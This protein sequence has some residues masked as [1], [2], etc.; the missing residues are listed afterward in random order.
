VILSNGNGY[1]AGQVTDEGPN[2]GLWYMASATATM[3][4]RTQ[5]RRE[6]RADGVP[7]SMVG[8]SAIVNACFGVF[9]NSN[10]RTTVE[11][12]TQCQSVPAFG[13][14][15]AFAWNHEAAHMSA[16]LS[17]AQGSQGNVYLLWE[18]RMAGSASEL[19]VLADKDYFDAHSAIS[20]AA[21]TH[22]GGSTTFWFWRFVGGG[23]NWVGT[24]TN[25]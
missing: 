22:T 12:N 25:H 7:Q 14:F 24:Q 3:Q 8:D 11:V 5:I 1:T 13:S 2:A 17:A 15:V 4:L 18:P 9:G 6:Y 16:A 19:H 20:S 10:K 23:W 21:N